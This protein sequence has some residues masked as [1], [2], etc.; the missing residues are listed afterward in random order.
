VSE[1]RVRIDHPAV[2]VELICPLR[3]DGASAHAIEDI[4]A[5]AVT[6]FR[7]TIEDAAKWLP[8]EL[9]DDEAEPVAGDDDAD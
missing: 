8:E 4:V 6:G 5:A 9:E 2:S 1:I 7:N 3:P